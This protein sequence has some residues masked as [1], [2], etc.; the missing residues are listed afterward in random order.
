V[1]RCGLQ[2]LAYT[3]N[4]TLGGLPCVVVLPGGV[5]F[6]RIICH[7]VEDVVGPKN[8]S[9]L[10]G[11]QEF[12]VS[13]NRSENTDTYDFFFEVSCV[14]VSAAAGR[15]GAPAPCVL[16][17]HSGVVSPRPCRPIWQQH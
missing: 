13:D 2:N 14:P 8:V 3:P 11:G 12:F 10:V 16:R 17:A 1:C 5:A 7:T 4:I 9:L 15:P 6:D